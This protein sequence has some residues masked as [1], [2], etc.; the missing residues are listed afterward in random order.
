MIAGVKIKN[1]KVIPDSRGR[2]MEIL[3]NDD[4]GFLES[5]GQVYFTTALP[6]VVK[7]WHYHQFQ[8]DNFTCVLGRIRLGLY[9][10]RDGSLTRGEANDFYLSPEEP[11]LIHIPKLVYHGFKC[12]SSVEAMV[13]NTVTRPYNYQNP[14]ELRQDPYDPSIPFDWRKD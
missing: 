8:D 14:D 1:L 6:G 4:E 12:V 3:R 13:I 2:L 10:N 11:K 5:F 9:D 7:A